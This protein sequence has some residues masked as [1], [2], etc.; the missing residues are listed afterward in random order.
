MEK[1]IVL[2]MVN[3][4]EQAN[5]ICKEEKEI[6]ETKQELYLQLILVTCFF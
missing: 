1:K 5:S 2:L 3:K 6:S 4:E